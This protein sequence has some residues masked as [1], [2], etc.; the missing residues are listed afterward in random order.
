[1]YFYIYWDFLRHQASL[2][3]AG[4]FLFVCTGVSHGAAGIGMTPSSMSFSGQAY[5]TIA[6]QTLII[7]NTGDATL[8]YTITSDMFWLSVDVTNGSVAAGASTSVVVNVAT[9][10]LAP[11]NYNGN[12]TVTDPSAANSPQ[13][14]SINLTI[15]TS[16]QPPSVVVDWGKSD[17]GQTNVPVGL[18]NAVAVSGGGYHSLALRSDGTAMGWGGNDHGQANVPALLTN[19]MAVACGQYHSL[20]LKS[21]GTVVAWGVDNCG[22]TNVP[23]GL[24]NVVAISAGYYHSLAL[25]SDGTVVVFGD[26]TYGQTNIPVGLTNVVAVSGGGYH[27]L[28]LR[29][30][31]TVVAWGNNTYGQTNVPVW[32]TNAVAVAG[33]GYGSLLLTPAALTC[34]H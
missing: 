32:L 22:Q 29:P 23:V 11:R 8:N 9:R 6:P 12:L 16:I 25:R 30:D 3:L 34:P 17:I 33:C 13:V 1:M 2:C 24:T 15:T 18:T 26:N 21:D 19:V 5:S 28:A 20:V 10:G 31:G 7:T 4:L 14:V 27:S